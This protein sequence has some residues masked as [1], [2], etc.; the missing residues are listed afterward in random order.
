MKNQSCYIYLNDR[1]RGRVDSFTYQ[2]ICQLTFLHG[3]LN[4]EV[5]MEVQPNLNVSETG[6]VWNYANSKNNFTSYNRQANSGM[7]N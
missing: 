1:S 5:Y 3:D 6:L 4:E 2:T 7:P